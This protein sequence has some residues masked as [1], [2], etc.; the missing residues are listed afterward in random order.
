MKKYLLIIIFIILSC[1]NLFLANKLFFLGSDSDKVKILN[2]TIWQLSREGYTENQIKEMRI[3][4]NPIK[5]GLI[6]YSVLV[7]LKS[8]NSTA[9][10]YS[11]SSTE[12]K[13][14]EDIGRTTP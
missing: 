6:P 7:V 14:V 12:E 2:A 8:D 10:I 5:G 13:Q 4:Y 9:R 11:W 3:R 1:S